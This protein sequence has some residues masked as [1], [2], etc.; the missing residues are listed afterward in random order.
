MTFA[1]NALNKSKKIFEDVSNKT[2]K[3]TKGMRDVRMLN[4]KFRCSN[5][6]IFKTFIIQ[7]YNVIA[8]LIL[9]NAAFMTKH[10]SWKLIQVQEDPRYQLMVD[11]FKALNTFLIQTHSDVNQFI[12]AIRALSFSCSELG[13]D[14]NKFVH[15]GGRFSI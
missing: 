9:Q 14:F 11:R 13:K 1:S 10:K 12:A 2:A 8:Y 3:A 5:F 6:S 7:C 15:S 4:T